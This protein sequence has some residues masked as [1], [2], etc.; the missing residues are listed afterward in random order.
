MIEGKGE[1]NGPEHL[2]AAFGT[3]FQ[4]IQRVSVESVLTEAGLLRDDIGSLQD[5]KLE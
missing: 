2:E 5:K 1:A 4:S 3:G